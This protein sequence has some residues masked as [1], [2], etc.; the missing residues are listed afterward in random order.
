M[1]CSA[2]VYL[3]AYILFKRGQISEDELS[4]YRIEKPW[5]IAL[6]GT[7]NISNF[8]EYKIDLSQYGTQ[9]KTDYLTF[10]LKSGNKADNLLR[11]YFSIND[12]L[13]RIIIGHLPDH[14]PIMSRYH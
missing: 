1:L 3:N 9:E 4:F 12:E 7:S 10:H 8:S 13:D 14:L 5:D 2:I 11:V 6:C